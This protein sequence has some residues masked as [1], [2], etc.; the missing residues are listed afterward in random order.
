MSA[1]GTSLV[2]L[3]G[4]LVGGATTYVTQVRLDRARERRERERDEAAAKAVAR[5]LG[6]DI[7]RAQTAISDWCLSN[8]SWW[9]GNPM[10]PD[11]SPDELA[12]VASR[13]DWDRW[14]ALGHGLGAFRELGLRRSH[15][16]DRKR[17]AMT[18]ADILF[19]QFTVEAL[20][21]AR[22]AIA[23]IAARDSDFRRHRSPTARRRHPSFTRGIIGESHADLLPPDSGVNPKN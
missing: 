4:V 1:V 10:R 13:L 15:A 2:G 19:A 17:A 11:P 20:E 7:Y 12:L 22:A 18:D 23:K 8:H 3:A 9:P 21:G 14:S 16:I 6:D 5:L